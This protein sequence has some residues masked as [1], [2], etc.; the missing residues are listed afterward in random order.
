MLYIVATPI[1]NLEDITLRAVRILGEVELVLAE[2]TR[3][4]GMLLKRLSIK[5]ELISF[6][7]HNEVKKIPSIIEKLREGKDIAI[8]SS[9]GTPTISDPGYKLIKTCR[10]EGIPITSLPGPSSIIN[11]LAL[12]SISHDKFVFLGYM[13][14]KKSAQK[15]LL[16][17]TKPWGINLVF[18]ESPYRILKSLELIKKSLGEVRLII[19][20]EMTKKFEEVLEMEV[21][22]AISY[23]SKKEPKGEFVMVIDNREPNPKKK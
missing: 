1:G 15:K 6:Y 23:F 21:S 3:K 5:K 16:E 20:R 18:F 7:E 12:S 11:C 4:T 9:A 17:K 2:D 14:R 10:E 13:P 22:E 8:V 19:A